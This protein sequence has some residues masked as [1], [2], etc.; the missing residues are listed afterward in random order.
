MLFVVEMVISILQL[1]QQGM[2]VLLEVVQYYL[3]LLDVLIKTLKHQTR[4]AHKSAHQQKLVMEKI[5][6]QMEKILETGIQ[7][8]ILDRLY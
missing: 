8:H 5:G 4:K 1:F 3:H 7:R 2:L 6:V